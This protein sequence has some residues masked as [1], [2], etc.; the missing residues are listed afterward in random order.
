[1][2]ILM[3]N[4]GRHNQN[5][6]G[7]LWWNGSLHYFKQNLGP[8]K[9]LGMI[10]EYESGVCVCVCMYTEREISMAKY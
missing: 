9:L 7:C 6:V 1:M 10:H 4:K 2:Q 5:R 3:Q 8:N